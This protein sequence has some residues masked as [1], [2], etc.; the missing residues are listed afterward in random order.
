MLGAHRGN[1]SLVST[2]LFIIGVLL[3]GYAA[4]DFGPRIDNGSAVGWWSFGLG[5]LFSVVAACLYII[6]ISLR[7]TTFREVGSAALISILLFI[8][9]L[10][11]LSPVSEESFIFHPAIAPAVLS[12]FWLGIAFYCAFRRNRNM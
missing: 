3:C 8:G 1:L 5:V 11:W 7:A 6:G 2:V 9:Y 12:V 10:L 4:Y